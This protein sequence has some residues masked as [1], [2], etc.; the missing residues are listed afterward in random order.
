MKI[1]DIKMKK[2]IL[3][4][5]INTDIFEISKINK[6]LVRQL[7]MARVKNTNITIKRSCRH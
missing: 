5:K 2:E 1:R 4:I 6:P 7:M 3:K